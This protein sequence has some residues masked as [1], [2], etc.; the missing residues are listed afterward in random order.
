MAN[1]SLT[2]IRQLADE[3]YLPIIVDHIE[4]MKGS[5]DGTIRGVVDDVRHCL[6]VAKM[7]YDKIPADL[8]VLKLRR[9]ID[10]REEKEADIRKSLE[11]LANKLSHS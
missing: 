10:F 6:I 8:L 11:E 3:S 5:V 7:D 2:T 1:Y 4:G 9:R